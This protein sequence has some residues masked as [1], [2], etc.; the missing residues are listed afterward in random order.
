MQVVRS[1]QCFKEKEPTVSTRT[2]AVWSM[3]ESSLGFF[4][5]FLTLNHCLFLQVI[6][7]LEKQAV[8]MVC[9][10]RPGVPGV[11]VR[12][13]EGC[14]ALWHADPRMAVPGSHLAV[15]PR[16]S[17]WFVCCRDVQP[18]APSHFSSPRTEKQPGTKPTI[19]CESPKY[20]E[21][22]SMSYF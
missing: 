17:S 5:F 1:V 7:A 20:Q 6:E 15:L 4:F 18:S 2:I 10:G 21:G 12:A 22:R 11:L 19:S 9:K 14:L 16:G 8:L 3:P 13:L